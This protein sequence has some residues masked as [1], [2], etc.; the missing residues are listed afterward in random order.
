MIVRAAGTSILLITQPDH[1][2]LAR[3]IMEH[4]TPLHAEPRQASILLA[5]GEHDNGWQEP[6]SEPALDDEGLVIDFV[7]ASNHLK[8]SVWPRAVARLADDPFAAALVAQH[9]VTVY[10]RFRSDPDWSAFFPQMEDL[11]DRDTERAHVPAAEVLRAYAY[12]RVGDLISLTFCN[13]WTDA[14]AYA[15]WTVRLTADDRVTVSPWRFDR[16]EFAIAVQSRTLPASPF[17]SPA[18]FLENL[19]RAPERTLT[20][21]VASRP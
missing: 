4:C 8:Q 9:A 7:R 10:D 13:A 20:G 17:R 12:V 15:D 16:G 1:A 21:V 5:I 6:D 18:E 2:A 11:R 3:R 14:Q 19:A